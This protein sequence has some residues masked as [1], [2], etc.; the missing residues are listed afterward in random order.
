MGA[1]SGKVT[2]GTYFHIAVTQCHIYLQLFDP[3]GQQL[4]DAT[5]TSALFLD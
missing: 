3:M 1:G 4:E 2:K 5:L